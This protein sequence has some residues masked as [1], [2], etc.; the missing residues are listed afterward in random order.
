MIGPLKFWQIY[1]CYV[2][3]LSARFLN[4]C[5]TTT[6]FYLLWRAGP[7]GFGFYGSGSARLQSWLGMV[8]VGRLGSM[9]SEIS[10]KMKFIIFQGC[11][12]KQATFLPGQSAPYNQFLIHLCL[13]Q[14]VIS[15]K[16][17]IFVSWNFKSIFKSILRIQFSL[18]AKLFSS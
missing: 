6:T 11:P 9:R 16:V 8:N 5:K 15:H 13:F 7:P 18:V 17:L 12:I 2:Y 14:N 3:L 1:C 10:L 4:M